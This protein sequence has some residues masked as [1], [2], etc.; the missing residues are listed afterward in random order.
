[1]VLPGLTAIASEGSARGSGS[2][3]D[4]WSK[5][6][7]SSGSDVVGD[8]KDGGSSGEESE[9]SGKTPTRWAPDALDV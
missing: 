2:N 4:G 6:E 1:M 3:L 7:D 8:S 9:D 5:D